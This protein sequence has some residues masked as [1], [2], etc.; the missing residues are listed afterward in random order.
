M[1]LLI[2]SVEH[3]ERSGIE[4]KTRA[5]KANPKPARTENPFA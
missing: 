2:Y 5:G 3:P 1:I 4:M